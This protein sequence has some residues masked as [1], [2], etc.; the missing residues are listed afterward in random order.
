MVKYNI[1]WKGVHYFFSICETDK[2]TYDMYSKYLKDNLQTTY[3][4]T[5]GHW[6]DLGEVFLHIK[7]RSLTFQ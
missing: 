2:G 5:E 4:Q 3:K 7:F 1:S 6:T